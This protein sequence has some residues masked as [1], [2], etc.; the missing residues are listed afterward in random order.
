MT[1]LYDH[2]I[3][4]VQRYGGISRYFFEIISR[5]A[6]S[7]ELEIDLFQGLNVNGYGLEKFKPHFRRYFGMRKPEIPR[8]TPLFS[9]ANQ[10]LLRGFAR[11]RRSDIYHSTYYSDLLPSFQGRRVVTV[12]DMIHELFPENFVGDPTSA[13]KRTAVERADRVISISHSTKQDLVRIFGIPPEK[14]EVVHL[15]N[16]LRQPAPTQRLFAD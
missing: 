5:L 12:Y 13:R 3:F 9:A 2:Q 16:S 8:A 11:T 7:G 14:I 15:A 1:C 6:R 10:L 4:Q